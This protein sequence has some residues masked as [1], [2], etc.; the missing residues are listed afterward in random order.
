MT[1]F[2]PVLPSDLPPPPSRD[3]GSISMPKYD[4]FNQ[5]F[6]DWDTQIDSY[7][8]SNS[9]LFF[10]AG[11][12][13]ML[14]YET[15]DLTFI[16]LSNFAHQF[17]LKEL[18]ARNLKGDFQSKEEIQ[19]AFVNAI[20]A[21]IYRIKVSNIG[22]NLSSKLDYLLGKASGS[23]H[24]IDRSVAM[25][26][27]LESVG[28]FDTPSGRKVLSQHLRTVF[29]DAAPVMQQNGRYVMESVLAGPNGVLKVETVWED[30]KL[31]IV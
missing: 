19:N 17:G 14:I 12:T 22:V 7:L 3:Y 4:N 6:R 9:P 1:D 27:Q 5:L 23:K 20:P 24:N 18:T 21:L 31:I 16:N 2:N 30:F 25:L 10:A 28:I 13:K 26:K 8:Y 11:V 15:I 29:K